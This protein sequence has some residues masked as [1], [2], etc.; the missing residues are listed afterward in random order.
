MNQEYYRKKHEKA[1]TD[2]DRYDQIIKTYVY[3][4]DKHEYKD[5]YLEEINL[6]YG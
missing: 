2:L 5:C 3:A 1:S 4:A 6:P